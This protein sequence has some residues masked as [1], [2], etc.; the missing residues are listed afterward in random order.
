MTEIADIKEYSDENGN[1]I[2]GAPDK[3]LKSFV[4]FTARNC[5]VIFE[6]GVRLQGARFS[7]Q[8]D[9]GLIHIKRDAEVKGNLRTGLNSKILIGSGLRVTGAMNVSS[10]E[11]ADVEIGDDCMFGV[12]IDIRSDDSH[13]IFD[14]KTGVRVN[15]SRPVKI[16]E[17]VWLAP[18][19]AVLAGAT[20]GEGCVV[21]YRS[22]VKGT[23]PPHSL[24]VGVPARVI[25][26]DIVWDRAHVS[27]KAPWHFDDITSV[28]AWTPKEKSNYK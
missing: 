3:Q 24:S 27:M 15:P 12:G 1:S 8:A 18:H 26:E 2:V 13:P 20:I 22:I 11:G 10:S 9:G 19:V 7:L 5:Q 23:L 25:K 16:G 17:H 21:G 4:V 6:P 28:N 14:R